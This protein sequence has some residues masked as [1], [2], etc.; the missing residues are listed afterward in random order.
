MAEM[1][2]KGVPPG[3]KNPKK[4]YSLVAKRE[5]Y[6]WGEATGTNPFRDLRKAD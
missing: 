4:P 2:R 6:T 1:I 5:G 3:K